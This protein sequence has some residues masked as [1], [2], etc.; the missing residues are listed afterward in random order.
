[1]V[2]TV[3]FECD[4][5]ALNVCASNQNKTKRAAEMCAEENQTPPPT[6]FLLFIFYDIFFLLRSVCFF[7]LLFAKIVLSP[8]R[9]NEP[10]MGRGR[11][12]PQRNLLTRMDEVT[13]GPMSVLRN[14]MINKTRVKVWIRGATWIR[15]F[16]TGYIAAF[17][18]QWNLAMT[19]VD[20]TFTRRRHRKTP[21]LGPVD[22]ITEAL[23]SLTTCSASGSQGPSGAALP[24]RRK[25]DPLTGLAIQCKPIDRKQELCQRHI[26]QIFIRG[27]QVALVAV[28]PV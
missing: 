3:E 2:S 14:C 22:H 12:R 16:C 4:P 8:R 15:G 7:Y 23:G 13:R 26:Q 1:M 24:N 18:K 20:E 6:F 5:L 11:S 19:D 25:P 21:I 28:L 27:E 17:D 10:V 9:G